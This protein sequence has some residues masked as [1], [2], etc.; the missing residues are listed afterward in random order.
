MMA[1][2]VSFLQFLQFIFVQILFELIL[3]K[4]SLSKKFTSLIMTLLKCAYIL[5][6]PLFKKLL[7]IK[8]ILLSYIANEYNKIPLDNKK[9][10]K[11]FVVLTK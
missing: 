5:E 2:I 6:E 3:F 10:N 1:L 9:L 4:L 11:Y 7:K 8:K